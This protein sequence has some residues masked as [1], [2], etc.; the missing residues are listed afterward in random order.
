MATVEGLP[1]VGKRSAADASPEGPEAEVYLVPF[2]IV[3]G[4]HAKNDMAGDRPVPG[5]MWWL[6]RAMP[7]VH[8]PGM[9]EVE[10]V[11]KLLADHAQEAGGP[12]GRPAGE[13]HQCGRRRETRS[14]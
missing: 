7:P 3:A 13:A 8:L 9:G 1:H 4:D 2:M 14:F 11:W 10:E 12:A 6:R 5:K